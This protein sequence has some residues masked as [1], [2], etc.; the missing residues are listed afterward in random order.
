[1]SGGICEPLSRLLKPFAF[2][3]LA[4][5]RGFGF[6]GGDSGFTLAGFEV[7]VDN[8][9]EPTILS[10]FAAIRFKW[11]RKLFL[12]NKPIYVLAGVRNSL[13]RSQVPKKQ[14]SSHCDALTCCQRRGLMF[15]FLPNA[16]NDEQFVASGHP[17]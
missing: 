5:V 16:D 17:K 8:V 1:L 4:T 10:V 15:L 3:A 11:R 2:Q 9:L 6:S 12:L 14:D 13:L 7:F